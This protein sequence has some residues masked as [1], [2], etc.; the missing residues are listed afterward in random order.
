[1]DAPE[2]VTEVKLSSDKHFLQFRLTKEAIAQGNA[3]VAV[4]DASNNIMWS[5]HIWVTPLVSPT[6]PATDL[7]INRTDN[8]YNFMQYNLGWATATTM[9]YGAGTGNNQPREIR[10]RV[11]QTGISNPETE[12]ISVTQSPATVATN[13]NNPFWQFGRKDPMPPSNGLADGAAGERQLWYGDA[14][15]TYGIFPSQISLGGAI[16]NPF[17]IIGGRYN[18]CPTN[19]NNLWDIS[20]SGMGSP[21]TVDTV[22]V[23]TIYDPNPVGFKMQPANAWTRMTMTGGYGLVPS[24]INASNVATFNEDG[25]YKF[26]TQLDGSGP[27]VQLQFTG[28]RSWTTCLGNITLSA[29][30]STASPRNLTSVTFTGYDQKGVYPITGT[31]RNLGL[32]VRPITD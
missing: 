9:N 12:I 7:M 1:M 16:Q 17:K 11:K 14:T 30:M 23:K 4:R 21:T 22:I 10:I 29:T 20:N 8:H 31:G 32:S 28:T 19:W 24:D 18:W 27:T 25:G 15:Y 26:Y 6:A 2:L 13:G 5:W 3:V